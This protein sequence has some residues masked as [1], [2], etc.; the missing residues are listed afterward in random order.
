M[1]TLGINA[2]FHD[3]S[4]CIVKDGV[5]LA[6]AEEERFTGIKHAK[7]P[8][9]FSAY[10]LPYHAIDYCLKEAGVP[11]AKVGHVAYSFDPRLLTGDNDP[12]DFI[13]LPLEP[14]RFPKSSKETGSAWDPLFLSFIVNAPRQLAG[15]SPHHLQERFRGA[16]HDGPYQWHFVEHHLAH[17]ASAFLASPFEEAAVMTLDGRGE[18]AT[19]AYY[20]GK[21]TT[22]APLE[23]VRFPH[24]LG[25]LYERITDHLGFLRSSDEYKVMAL[26]SFGAPSFKRQ[27]RGLITLRGGRYEIKS[28]SPEKLFGPARRRGA[29]LE[30]RHYDI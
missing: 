30:K 27:F 29:L 20:L 25:L 1:H 7:R 2:A 22:L 9:P 23:E 19:T 10:E 6:A 16:R 17:A 8:V 3:S 12:G 11:L 28:F 18:R 15:G 13:T 4:A 14:G 5:V 21:G 26:A 24:S